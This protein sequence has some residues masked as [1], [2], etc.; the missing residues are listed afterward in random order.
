MVKNDSCCAKPRAGCVSGLLLDV[1]EKSCVFCAVMR[2]CES[3]K[4]G[5]MVSL[6][7]SLSVTPIHNIITAKVRESRNTEWKKR[8]SHDTDDVIEPDEWK[9]WEETVSIDMG[10]T[11]NQSITLGWRKIKYSSVA[12]LWIKNH[13]QQKTLSLSRWIYTTYFL[14]ACHTCCFFS[15]NLLNRNTYMSPSLPA[16]L[17]IIVE[18]AAHLFPS[19]LNFR[20]GRERAGGGGEGKPLHMSVAMG[21]LAQWLCS[22]AAAGEEDL[23]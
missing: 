5:L 12:G 7:S 20:V 23:F 9:Q 6:S 10:V 16:P 15:F 18:D 17:Y 19:S 22:N 11:L 21:I 13:V 2:W 1:N 4:S 14:H 3:R 8:G